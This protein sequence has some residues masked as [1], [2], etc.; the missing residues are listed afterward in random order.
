MPYITRGLLDGLLEMSASQEPSS[1]SV[2]LNATA[3]ENF[4]SDI[5]VEPTIEILSHFYFPQSEAP[6][7]AVFGMELG[8]PAGRGKARFISHPQGPPEPTQRDT[9]AGV[10]IIAIPPWEADSCAVYDR[11][12][13]R[14]ELEIINAAPPENRLDD[15]ERDL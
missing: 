3:A 12:S 11:H 5:T 14:L 7:T 4:D 1:L 2:V 6:V 8:V 15:S 9:H 13:N 10:I